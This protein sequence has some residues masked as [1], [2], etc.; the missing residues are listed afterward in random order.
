MLQTSDVATVLLVGFCQVLNPAISFARDM[1][2]HSLGLRQNWF[3]P[4]VVAIASVLLYVEALYPSAYNNA[5]ILYQQGLPFSFRLK[6]VIQNHIGIFV[7]VVVLL[8]M[9]RYVRR[10]MQATQQAAT[11]VSPEPAVSLEAASR[12]N[13]IWDGST[14]QRPSATLCGAS[15]M[16]H[17]T[18]AMSEIAALLPQKQ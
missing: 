5:D 7:L 2:P 11:Q 17:S 16:R 9:K 10:H 3:T 4:A 1:Q 8:L 12:H 13:S 6:L 14:L 18:S 15:S